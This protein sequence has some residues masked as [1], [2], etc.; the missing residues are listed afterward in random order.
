MKHQR[1]RILQLVPLA[2]GASAFFGN[3]AAAAEQEPGPQKD[4][5]REKVVGIGG[6]FFR[7]HDPDALA[8]WYQE[9][10]GIQMTPTSDNQQVW[11]QEAGE[12]AFTPFP[13]K[14]KYFGDPSKMWMINFRVRDLGKMAAQLEAAG[15][16]VKIDP[17]AYP[18]GRFASL[19]DPEGN[20]IQLW[21][22]AK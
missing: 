14:T 10:L 20:P 19:N 6:F 18:Y 4:A 2:I 13:E 22:P 3:V 7:A 8:K 12:T 5:G 1:R 9:H 11:R 15:I 17:Q 21:Q 16:N